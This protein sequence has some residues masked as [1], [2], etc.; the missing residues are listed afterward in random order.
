MQLTKRA[1]ESHSAC[2][3]SNKNCAHILVHVPNLTVSAATGIE[4]KFI[5]VAV[6]LRRRSV[7]V[8]RLALNLNLPDAAFALTADFVGDLDEVQH[9]LLRTNQ[10]AVYREQ[11]AGLTYFRYSMT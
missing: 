6:V 4:R 8:E 11:V 5:V 9:I 1:L 10:Y 7:V 3:A 2:P